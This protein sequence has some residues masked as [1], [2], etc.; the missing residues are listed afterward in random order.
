ML[1]TVQSRAFAFVAELWE[2][3]GPGAWHFISLPEAEADAIDAESGPQKVGFG[4]VPV[5][6]R[7]GTTEWE[8]SIFPDRKRATYVL[9][10]KKAVRTAEGLL[11][12]TSV[13][14]ELTVR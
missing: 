5:L 4:S 14:V 3:D 7:I 11:A 2:H 1:W 6:V 10:V 12:G 13:E 9:P 8:T